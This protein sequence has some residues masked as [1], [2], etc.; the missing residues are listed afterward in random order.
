MSE[1]KRITRRQFLIGATGV[2]VVVIGGTGYWAT[3]QPEITFIEKT[4]GDH[5]TSEHSILVAYASQYGTT[6]GVADAI[7]QAFFEQGAAVDVRRVE[8]VS[9]VEQ[10]DAVV[11]GAPI[12]TEE[13]KTE[14][15][16]FVKKHRDMLSTVPVAYFLTCMTLALSTDDE[17]RADMVKPLEKID[18]DFP[19]IGPIE[20]GLFAGAVDYSDMSFAMQA[21]Y[22]LFSEDDT[23]G[24]FRDFPAI[25][26]WATT[27]YPQ[28]MTTV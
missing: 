12:Q 8:N 11:I 23:S 10:Y 13:W 6:S 9:N 28:L 16:D 26:A 19:E 3:R 27:L 21:A 7:G 15:R 24:D 4:Y 14:A 18:K 20:F 22:R 17:E 5:N 25:R 2:S 1:S